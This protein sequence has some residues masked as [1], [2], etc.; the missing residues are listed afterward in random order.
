IFGFQPCFFQ[1]LTAGRFYRIDVR[2]TSSFGNFPTPLVQW[3]TVLTYQPGVQLF[4]QRQNSDGGVLER[5]F[6]VDAPVSRRVR[7]EERRVG[8]ECVS[9]CRF[10]GSLYL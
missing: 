6:S 5:Y 4:I 1:Q 8:K 10:W 9:T 3:K 2:R 7:S